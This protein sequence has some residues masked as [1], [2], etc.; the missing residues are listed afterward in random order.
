MMKK[1][2]ILA[3]AIFSFVTINA[4]RVEVPDYTL[5]IIN[6]DD[7]IVYEIDVFA[8]TPTILLPSTLSGDF[9]LYLVPSGSDYYFYGDITL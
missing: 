2:I 3:F 4:Q 9:G 5:Y 7:D 6:E 8:S 1:A